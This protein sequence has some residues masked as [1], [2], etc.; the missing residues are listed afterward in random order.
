MD[1]IVLEDLAEVLPELIALDV[2]VGDVEVGST[3]RPKIQRKMHQIQLINAVIG[4]NRIRASRII[5][6]TAQS[7]VESEAKR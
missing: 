2:L 5:I 4:Y 6:K 1:S 7:N 3:V